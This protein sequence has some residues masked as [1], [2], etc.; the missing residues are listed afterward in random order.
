MIDAD[1]QERA[2]LGSEHVLVLQ[3]QADSPL[4]ERWI[5][6]ARERKVRQLL[7]PSEIQQ[8]KDDRPWMKAFDRALEELVCSSSVGNAFRIT[9]PNSVR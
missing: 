4:R 6:G 1:A 5:A 9:K 3:E 2:Q 8:S 7:V